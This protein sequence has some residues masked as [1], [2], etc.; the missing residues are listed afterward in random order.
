MRISIHSFLLAVFVLIIV[1]PRGYAQDGA[2]SDA[3]TLRSSQ[4]SI[5]IQPVIYTEL[6][7]E[8]ML[9]L[10]GGYGLQSGLS[11]YGK[12]GVLREEPYVGGHFK[13]QLAG[14]PSDVLSFSILGGA[15]SFGDIGLKLGGILSKRIGGFSLYSGLLYE[16]LF[17][18]NIRNALLLPIGVDVP[19]SDSGSFIFEADL[20]VNDDGRA[21]Q[22]LHIGLN[23]YF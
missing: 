20:A 4:L 10:R 1:S 2:F 22:A 11:F 15:Y 9:I 8:F 6:D 7:N 23:F 21:Y 5:G 12:L 19:L 14:E 17:T 18:S 13:Y 16:P 3:N